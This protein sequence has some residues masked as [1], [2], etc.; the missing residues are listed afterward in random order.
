MSRFRDLHPPRLRGLRSA[1]PPP[2]LGAAS[3][4]RQSRLRAAPRTTR[5]CGSAFAALLILSTLSWASSAWAQG[6]FPGVGRAATPKEVAAW[7]IDV[8]PDFKGLPP[9]SGTVDKGQDIWEA[10]CASCHGVFGEANTVFFPLIGGTTKD[11]V[12]RGNVASLQRNDYPGRTTIMKA[13]TVSTLWDY[14]NRA[15]PWNEPKSL[16]PDEVY[17][18]TAFLLH[19]ADV[20]PQSF[21]LSDKNI[22]QVQGMLPNR[23]G[24]TT[25]HA[26]WPGKELGGLAKP[27]VN[28]VACMSNCP[29]DAKVTSVLPVHARDAHGNLRQQNRTVGQQRGSDTSKPE[30]MLG[31]AAGPVKVV[32][33]DSAA[34]SP[35]AAAIALTQTHACTACHAVDG[36][37]V[38]PSFV[39]IGRKYSGRADYLA[40]KI[41]AGGS[42]VWGDIP[43]PPQN[44]PEGDLKTMAGWLAAG[45]GK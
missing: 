10:K 17:A 19:L 25:K 4:A 29:V 5:A 22:A 44:L 42:G 16:K 23:N 43:M 18:V 30:G 7:D 32:G 27:D 35:N 26:L 20:V 6:N 31:D 2:P 38:G 33:A 9:G 12:K 41:K 40:G 28:A 1:A 45:A 36:K 13:A 37:L 3:A 24:M 11:D 8:R 21:T 15:M 39:D 34:T 14:I